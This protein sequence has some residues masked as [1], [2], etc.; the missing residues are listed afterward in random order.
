MEI[1]SFP[2]L[3]LWHLVLKRGSLTSVLGSAVRL[4]IVD[5]VGIYEQSAYERIQATRRTRHDA[6][7]QSISASAD[8]FFSTP[9]ISIPLETPSTISISFRSLTCKEPV[10]CLIQKNVT[11]KSILDEVA[12]KLGLVADARITLSFD[13]DQVDLSL[14]PQE[15]GLE[16][17]DLV[18]VRVE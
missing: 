13:G 17:D 2:L 14:S 1:A 9:S 11:F 6:L 8:N 15:V 12:G 18:E 16:N 10:Q 3:L 5:C 4:V 7:L